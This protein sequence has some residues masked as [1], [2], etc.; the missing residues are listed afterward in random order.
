MNSHVG[1]QARAHDYEERASK[2]EQ[3]VVRSADQN[4]EHIEIDHMEASAEAEI[5]TEVMDRAKCSEEKED[6]EAENEAQT[7]RIEEIVNA[8]APQDV[9]LR[10]EGAIRASERLRRRWHEDDNE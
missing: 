1:L 5:K 4:E 6:K 8:S 7:P 3:Q 2:S 10:D 9:Q